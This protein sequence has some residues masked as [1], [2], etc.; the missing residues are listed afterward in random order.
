[1][2]ASRRARPEPW[3][4]T[5]PSDDGPWYRY[6]PVRHPKGPV[7][8]LLHSAL[9][10]GEDLPEILRTLDELSDVEAGP[11][12]LLES[13]QAAQRAEAHAAALKAHY[14]ARLAEADL[15]KYADRDGVIDVLAEQ[16][17]MT[18]GTTRAAAERLVRTGVVTESLL[19]ATGEAMHS[20]ALTADKGWILVDALG[21]QAPAV[22]L[23][24]EELVLPTAPERT[25]TELRRDIARALAEIDPEAADARH[26]VARD[27]RHVSRPQPL[28]DS[29]ARLSVFLPADQAVTLDA[30]LNEIARTAHSAGDPRTLCHLRVDALADWAATVTQDGWDITSLTGTP[31]RTAPARIN[32]T[33]PLEVLAH[34]VPGHTPPPTVGQVLHRDL[35]GELS[36]QGEEPEAGPSTAPPGPA[37]GHRTEAAWLEGYGPVARFVALLLAAGGTW[38]RIVTDT[39]TGAPL[40]VGR[41]RY[42][43]PA[44]I[45]EAVRL[46]DRVCTRP[47]CSAPARHCELDHVEP[48][49]LGGE[50]SAANLACACRRC[51]RIHTVGGGGPGP[52]KPD[53]SRDW[54]TATG[55]TYRGHPERAPRQRG[56]PAPGTQPPTDDPPPF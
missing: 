7:E 25:T 24:V 35:H 19:M 53:G 33:V 5:A 4:R 26:Q 27:R 14:A 11:E 32:V 50:T 1:M 56:G 36:E 12:V 20:G 10:E 3:W 55:H 16:V 38:R 6:N 49:A 51:H 28:P 34:A 30:A 47:G 45:A 39:I 2:S 21:D 13:L 42:S 44:H 43:P 22:A 9:L 46:R 48:W 18:L 31:N 54:R 8:E 37:A 41:E 29:M 15:H 52:L 17:G 40:D 23:A